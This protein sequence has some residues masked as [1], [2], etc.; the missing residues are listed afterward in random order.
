MQFPKHFP[1]NSVDSINKPP[2]HF[3]Q[4]QDG[5]QIVSGITWTIVYILYVK[6]SN[7]D[8]SYGMPMV[9]LYT[10]LSSYLNHS[11]GI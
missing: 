5:L 4:I 11:V 10:S 6:Q 1:L 2:L 9:A 8:K 3:L 7:K